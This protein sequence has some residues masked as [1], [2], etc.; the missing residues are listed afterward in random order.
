MR[1]RYWVLLG[2]IALGGIGNLIGSTDT[3]VTAS[4]RDSAAP[5]RLVVTAP[6][7]LPAAATPAG[8]AAPQFEASLYVTA[9]SLNLRA[10]PSTAGRVLGSLSRNSVVRVGARQGG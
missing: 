10:S 3:P 6:A 7:Q 4:V 5:A 8:G 9:N 1:K 2:L